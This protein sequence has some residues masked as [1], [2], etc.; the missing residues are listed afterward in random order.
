MDVRVLT[1]TAAELRKIVA[2]NPYARED[3]TKVVV[4]FLERAP[5]PE[6]AGAR[7]RR[8]SRPRA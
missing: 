6:P 5:T 8:R 2:G 1:R 4:T 7:P 3:P